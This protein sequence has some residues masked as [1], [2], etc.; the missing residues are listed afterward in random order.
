MRARRYAKSVRGAARRFA[1][2]FIAAMRVVASRRRERCRDD[3]DHH[4]RD[5]AVPK[6]S[7]QDYA[8]V[9]YACLLMPPSPI[10]IL[11]CFA[12]T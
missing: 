9:N 8:R 7:A 11:R 12:I 4:P 10:D 1:A 2:G 6:T 3:I 5:A